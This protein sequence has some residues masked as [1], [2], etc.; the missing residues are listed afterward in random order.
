MAIDLRITGGDVVTPAGRRP[1]DVLVD[2]EKIV[3]LVSS[4]V[5]ISEVGRTIDASGKLVIPGMVDPHVHTREPGFTHKE[6]ITTST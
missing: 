5:E 1:A 4:S 3:G 6:D 2:G